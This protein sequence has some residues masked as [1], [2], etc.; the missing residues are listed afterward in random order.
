MKIHINNIQPEMISNLDFESSDLWDKD[1]VI[2]GNGITVVR[3]ASGTG[4]STF[5]SYL[6]GQRNDYR[7][8][9]LFDEKDINRLTINDWAELRK[10]R[11]STVF[12]TLKL[13][14]NL[15]V[16]D[17][18]LVKN[19]LTDFYQLEEI[20]HFMGVLGIQEQ[21]NQICKT[22]SM[23]QKQ[24]VAIIRALC[25]PTECFILDEPFSHL[26]P[27]NTEIALQLILD[28]ASKQKAGI[29]LT[30]L[31]DIYNLKEAKVF[32]L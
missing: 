30:T 6:T 22:L 2:D 19:E 18:I 10:N 23:G 12:Q 28:E 27:Q 21:K 25:Q 31:D 29:I 9:I 20:E 13:F 5:V 17:N 24:R 32:N 15:T 26:D 1:A 16:L 14:E 3:A 4:K 8:Q 11:I 7:G